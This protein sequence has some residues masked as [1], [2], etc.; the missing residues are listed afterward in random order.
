MRGLHRLFALLKSVLD[1]SYRAFNLS[2]GLMVMWA[3]CRVFKSIFYAGVLEVLSCV[4]WAVVAYYFAR[5]A[6][7]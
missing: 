6:K 5:Y 4:L 1:G 3:A 2:V 7:F